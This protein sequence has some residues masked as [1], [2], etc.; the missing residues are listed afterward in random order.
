MIGDT[1]PDSYR[2]NPVFMFYY[3]TKTVIVF[4]DFPTFCPCDSHR[5]WQ[6]DI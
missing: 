6:G 4:S 2:D 1:L 5:I 3:G